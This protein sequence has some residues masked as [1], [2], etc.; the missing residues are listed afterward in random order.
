MSKYI[1]VSGDTFDLI[2]YKQLGD[3]RYVE[4]VINANRE[5]LTTVIFKAGHE[6]EIPEV[7]K[8]V[9]KKLP[10]WRQKS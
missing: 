4:E 10:P 1:T 2:S 9:S 7:K 5:Y 3:C 6:I 8:S